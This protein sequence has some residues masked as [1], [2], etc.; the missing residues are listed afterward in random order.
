MRA[1]SP[2]G[3]AGVLGSWEPAGGL[4]SPGLD[5]CNVALRRFGGGECRKSPELL[6][7]VPWGFEVAHLVS[8]LTWDLQPEMTASPAVKWDRNRRLPTHLMC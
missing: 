7:S 2:E 1:F 6:H 5:R 4:A 8:G 3:L